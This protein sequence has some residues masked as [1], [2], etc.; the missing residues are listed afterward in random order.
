MSAGVQRA[1][2]G[3]AAKKV[4]VVSKSWCGFCRR[5]KSV[6][7]KYSISEDNLE[8]MEIDGLDD[9]DDIQDYMMEITGGRSVS[10]EFSALSS[11]TTP[12][13]RKTAGG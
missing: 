13:S 2:A 6:L 4:F 11:V 10:R 7:A 5:A 12:S 8:I 3:I 1:K 9:C